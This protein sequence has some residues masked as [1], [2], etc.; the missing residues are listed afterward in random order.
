[1]VP[2]QRERGREILDQHKKPMIRRFPRDALGSV[3]H[4]GPGLFPFMYLP[5]ERLFVRSCRRLGNSLRP[6]FLPLCA[7]A[8]S[9]GCRAWVGSRRNPK[10]TYSLIRFRAAYSPGC[11][12]CSSSNLRAS[13]RAIFWNVPVGRHSQ[14][15]HKRAWQSLASAFCLRP[16][17]RNHWLESIT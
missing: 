2:C 6:G 14:P 17:G 7:S 12:W 3:G 8:Q 16:G 9:E 5:H 11:V 13:A 1:M 15:A 10:G 4:P